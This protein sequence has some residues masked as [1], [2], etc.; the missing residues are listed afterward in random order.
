M[1]PEFSIIPSDG[2]ILLLCM[3]KGTLLPTKH[4]QESAQVWAGGVL[5]IGH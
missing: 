1:L 4:G 5:R 2:K 3:R